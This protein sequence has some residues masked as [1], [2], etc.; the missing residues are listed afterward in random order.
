MCLYFHPYLQPCGSYIDVTEF[1]VPN[2]KFEKEVYF[3]KTELTDC[4]SSEFKSIFGLVSHT[5]AKS[6]RDRAKVVKRRLLRPQRKQDDFLNKRKKPQQT[7]SGKRLLIDFLRPQSSKQKLMMSNT[8]VISYKLNSKIKEI[9]EIQETH[10]F[11]TK[12]KQSSSP[13]KA[14]IKELEIVEDKVEMFEVKQT[15]EMKRKGM[16]LPR[17]WKIFG[18]KRESETKSNGHVYQYFRIDWQFKAPDGKTYKS[19]KKALDVV[20]HNTRYEKWE[21]VKPRNKAPPPPTAASHK[22]EEDDTPEYV[23]LKRQVE[24]ELDLELEK[25]VYGLSGVRPVRKFPDN[26]VHVLS[27]RDKIFSPISPSAQ[28]P[29]RMSAAVIKNNPVTPGQYEQMM[30]KSAIPISRF[31]LSQ[32]GEVI[33][34]K[35]EGWFSSKIETLRRVSKCTD[36]LTPLSHFHHCLARNGWSVVTSM[37]RTQDGKVVVQIFSETEDLV[38]MDLE[39]YIIKLSTGSLYDH[40][41]SQPDEKM[42]ANQPVFQH[43]AV[44]STYCLP[45]G[46]LLKFLGSDNSY[47]KYSRN[48]LF[49]S[50][51]GLVLKNIESV[52]AHINEISAP[53]YRS[54]KK[55]SLE[56]N[57]VTRNHDT[58]SPLGTSLFNLAKRKLGGISEARDNCSDYSSPHI[59][60]SDSKPSQEDTPAP[61]KVTSLPRKFYNG[62]QKTPKK[63]TYKNLTPTSKKSPER[64]RQIR[65]PSKLKEFQQSF[66]DS[67]P[68]VESTPRSKKKAYV[69]I[70][71]S[72]PRKFPVNEIIAKNKAEEERESA[73]HSS[74]K[75]NKMCTTPPKNKGTS[76]GDSAISTIKSLTSVRNKTNVVI[77]KTPEKTQT[78]VRRTLLQSLGEKSG[79]NKTDPPSR[80]L[81]RSQGSSKEDAGDT[82]LRVLHSTLGSQKVPT[83]S[84]ARKRKRMTD[85]EILALISSPKHKQQ[86]PELENSHKR[87]TRKHPLSERRL[88]SER[89]ERESS[90]E[91]RFLSPNEK[92]VLDEDLKCDGAGWEDSS[93]STPDSLEDL[94][95]DSDDDSQPVDGASNSKDPVEDDLDTLENSNGSNLVDHSSN[96]KQKSRMAR[97]SPRRKK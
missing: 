90:S 74:R 1:R 6:I 40:K 16:K 23:T 38:M 83:G 45:P 32:I 84:P 64:K 43:K 3:N 92:M 20:K 34:P 15:R 62:D 8:P 55:S 88:P 96:N 13:V 21:V 50:P 71:R 79:L 28:C 91:M 56:S 36:V 51:E 33:G 85:G 68:H 35:A 27:P 63:E 69:K 77:S 60:D 26:I 12:P 11:N 61:H 70:V 97:K 58:K 59:S 18:R 82:S 78:T 54:P 30:R 81:K 67:E 95:A 42:D 29:Q 86:G 14:E 66:T 5:E 10:T 37:P 49:I 19:L 39:Q 94:L 25:D 73:P 46:W 44:K 22:H 52:I 48:V 75:Q 65:R 4:N 7:E 87:M 80:G 53:V 2:Q 9:S 47:K 41:Q 57:L 93:R 76:P 24:E 17:G 31:R 89:N 72:L